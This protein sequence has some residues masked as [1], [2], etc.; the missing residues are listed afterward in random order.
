MESSEFVDNIGGILDTKGGGGA[1]YLEV[2][3]S[4]FIV[5]WAH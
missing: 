4:V 1:I 5:I 3:I 2:D